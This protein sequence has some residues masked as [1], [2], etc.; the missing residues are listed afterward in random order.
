MAVAVDSDMK[1]AFTIGIQEQHT[2][3][4][5]YDQIWM[6]RFE[7]KVDGATAI[8]KLFMF[9]F[10]ISRDFDLWVG[11]QEKHHIRINKTRPVFFA[12][13]QPHTYTI[14]V[15]GVFANKFDA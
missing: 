3:S 6:G 10:K 1:H 15:D 7:I 5:E 12:G 11:Y 9:D 4:I 8:S 14:W 13:L 2:V